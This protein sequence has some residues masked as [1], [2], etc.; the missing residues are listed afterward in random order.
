MSGPTRKVPAPKVTA[1]VAVVV[2]V[3]V[4]G[5]DVTVTGGD[6]TVTGGDVT[7]TG[8]DVSVTGGDVTVTGDAVTVACGNT[9]VTRDVTGGEVTVTA[10]RAFWA[11]TETFDTLMHCP[12][13]RITLLRSTP[14]AATPAAKRATPMKVRAKIRFIDPVFGP[15]PDAP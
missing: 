11:Q 6:V 3:T 1:G 10:G 15:E 2:T 8:A 9:T 4:T 5:G 7:V 14:A 13:F 12:G